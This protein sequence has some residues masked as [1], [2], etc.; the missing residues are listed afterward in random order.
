MGSRAQEFSNERQ[1]WFVFT[2]LFVFLIIIYGNSFQGEWHFDDYPAILEKENVHFKDLSCSEFKKAFTEEGVSRLKRPFADLTLGI[3]YYFG[4]EDVLGYHLVNFTIHY[5]CSVFLF[6]LIYSTL[7]LPLLEERYGE[8]TYPIAVLA[9]FFW[10]THPVQVNAVTYICQRMAGM[11]A[12][13]YIMA[14]YFYVKARTSDTHWRRACFFCA[15]AFSGILSFG[16]KQN[17]A[18]L[19]LSIFLYDLFLIQGIT[20]DRLKKSAKIIVVPL[21]ILTGL[22]FL[23]VDISRLSDI[24]SYRP[25]TLSERLLTEPRVLLLYLSLLVY[26]ISSRLGL[27]HDMDISKTLFEPWSTLPAI[28]LVILLNT[29]ALYIA[30]KRPL[31]SFCIIFFFLNHLIEGS[32]IPLELVFEHRNYLPSTFLFVLVA[33]FTVH[34]LDYFSNR[35]SIQALICLTVVILLFCQSHTTYLRNSILKTEISLW[36]DEVEKSP[37]LS[38]PHINLSKALFE[39]GYAKEGV[40]ELKKAAS[41]KPD[42]N[43]KINATATH[44]LAQYYLLTGELDKSLGLFTEALELYPLCVTAYEGISKI[45]FLRGSLEEAEKNIRKAI[46]M[47]PDCAQFHRTLSIVLL[48]IGRVNDAIKEARRTI[49]LDRTLPEPFYILGEAFR[50]KERWPEASDYF[51]K[52]LDRCP[53]DLNAHIALVEVYAKM[54]AKDM[55]QQHIL[56]LMEGKGLRDVVDVLLRFDAQINFLDHARTTNVF[57]SIKEHMRDE[58]QKLQA[59]EALLAEGLGEKNK[60]RQPLMQ[61]PA[62]DMMGY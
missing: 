11:A 16:T 61:G 45:M 51:E 12:L 31:I 53:G 56:A 13:F 29:Y 60:W 21:L 22:G 4:K 9:V 49:L 57:A 3:N 43:P 62:P 58:I 37:S 18:M 17:S 50:I 26:P 15:C 40:A 8:S 48:R 38:R 2:I 19:P 44:N 7:R 1:Y 34:V 27:L 35:R 23:Y 52:F 59:A 36:R 47:E 14:M 28:L 25:F 6:L 54:G 33:L 42:M 24:Y 30:R 55:E 32:I 39:A 20:G 41:S 46:S 5:L 10:A